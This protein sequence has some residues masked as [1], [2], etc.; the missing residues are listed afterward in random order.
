[1]AKEALLQTMWLG[2]GE[3][4]ILR[5]RILEGAKVDLQQSKLMNESM[6]RMAVEVPFPV[7]I[8]TRANFIW[9]RDAQEFLAANSDFRLAVAIIT[10]N[11]ISRLITNSYVKFFKPAYPTKIF[12]SEEKAIVWLKEKMEEKKSSAE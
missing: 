2:F 4:K 1:M 10:N 8:D 6:L 12:S 9:E 11:P 7:L 5:V 3:D